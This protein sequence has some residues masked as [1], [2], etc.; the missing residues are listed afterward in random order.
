MVIQP[1]ICLIIKLITVFQPYGYKSQPRTCGTRN[2]KQTQGAWHQ[3]VRAWE[4]DW[5][6]PTAR[7]PHIGKGNNG[8]KQ[9]GQ[10]L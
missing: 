3:Q 5:C 7:Q 6:D 10:G 9:T 8:D 2:R 1:N 4:E